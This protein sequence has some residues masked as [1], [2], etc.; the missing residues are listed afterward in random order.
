[1][2]K[3]FK[4]GDYKI[5]DGKTY[6]QIISLIDIHFGVITVKPGDK[7]GWIS[8]NVL[9]EEGECWINE[10]SI[11]SDSAWISGNA[12]IMNSRIQGHCIISGEAFIQDA[13][14]Q[15]LGGTKSIHING[16][17]VI[18]H[19]S[20]YGSI[21]ICKNA[22]IIS[23]IVKSNDLFS[24]VGGTIN[25]SSLQFIN[26]TS[27]GNISFCE[28]R[29]VDVF[30]APRAMIRHVKSEEGS[31]GMIQAKGTACIDN[32]KLSGKIHLSFVHNSKSKGMNELNE[33]EIK[34]SNRGTILDSV[35]QDVSI[36]IENQANMSQCKVK[37]ARLH[38][39]DYSLLQES[40]IENAD[41]KLYDFS[42]ISK[43]I[44]EHKA[45]HLTGDTQK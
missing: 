11:V 20:I 5:I 25:N 44:I 41:I 2:N 24:I 42:S 37:H 35:Y 18:Q 14:I 15:N 26:G 8:G 19:S 9:S 27:K 17:S 36:E 39:N 12:L 31:F 10:S 29:D 1:M 43:Q 38:M 13:A 40:D 30:V 7:G 23:S 34:V 21:E 32:W 16:Q 22:K 28:L 33:G 4:L 45:V 6:Y 3:K